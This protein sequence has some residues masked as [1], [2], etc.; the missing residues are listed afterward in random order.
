MLN[1]VQAIMA[2]GVVLTA[3]SARGVTTSSTTSTTTTTHPTTTT[4]PRDAD[5]DGVLNEADKCPNTPPG[6]KVNRDGC[7][8]SQLCPCDAPRDASQWKS[9][10]QYFVCVHRAL[11]AFKKAKLIT[12]K[13]ALDAFSTA[14]KTQCGAKVAGRVSGKVRCCV[15]QPWLLSKPVCTET[16][17]STCTKRRGQSM[18][19]GSCMPNPC[20]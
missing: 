4:V 6:E 9:H 12:A 10:G 11:N 3:T 16:S 18:D 15:S 19:A 2:A 20:R 7:S 14:R 13:D 5:K 1:R 8:I 17:A